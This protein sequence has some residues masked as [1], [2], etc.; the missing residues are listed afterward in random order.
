MI[1]G[2]A[3]LLSGCAQL[4]HVQMSE[5]DAREKFALVPFEIKVS[6][7]G[8]DL[9]EA[10]HIQRSLFASSKEANAAGDI[11]AIVALFQLGPRTGAPVYSE[12]YA[13]KM[14]FALHQQCPSGG[15]TGVTSIRE[16]RSYPVIKG[17]IVKI[18]GYC[19]RSRTPASETDGTN[20]HANQLTNQPTDQPTDQL[21]DE[22]I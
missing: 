18:K 14:I 13:E 21:F 8:V 17:E 4:H 11:A 1:F 10:V 15:I 7:V 9:N 2:F 12:R 22:D 16:T 20:Q 19:L 6:E 3:F 5:I